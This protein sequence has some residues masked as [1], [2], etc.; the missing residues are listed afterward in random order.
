VCRSDVI[1]YTLHQGGNAL[2]RG[3]TKG[4]ADIILQKC[5]FHREIIALVSPRLYIRSSKTMREST[6]FF[7]A[8]SAS[9]TTDLEKF[10]DV[11]AFDDIAA[12][13]LNTYQESKE[14]AACADFLISQ[15]FNDLL[16]DLVASFY[17]E[18][19]SNRI[20]IMQKMPHSIQFIHNCF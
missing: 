6:T 2:S 18:E 7:C 4:A 14:F 8:G 17:Y 10:H 19:V 12:P 3:K 20:T 13:F 15:P 9:L 1:N 11:I 16:D 5:S